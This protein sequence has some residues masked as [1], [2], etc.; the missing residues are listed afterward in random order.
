MKPGCLSAAALAVLMLWP[1]VV[2]AQ[3]KARAASPAPSAR[4]GTAA[5][6]PMPS[7]VTPRSIDGDGVPEYQLNGAAQDG[8]LVW[9]GARM[10]LSLAVVLVLLGIG[11][12]VM[13]R[14][15]GLGQRE[16]AAGPLQVLGR[17][18]LTAKE[19]VCLVRAGTE[20]LVVGVSPAG[21]SLLHRLEGG[22]AEPPS[23]GATSPTT[24]VGQQRAS[25]PSGRWR[26]LAARIR[27]VQALWAIRPADSGTKR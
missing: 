19:A 16:T 13:R 21:V 9:D 5:E 12:K 6:H 10:V 11:L 27:D 7:E 14:W 15:P 4:Q 18:P 3:A 20:V 17:L 24:R 8:S 2:L 25:L 1:T 23:V 26:E 22:I